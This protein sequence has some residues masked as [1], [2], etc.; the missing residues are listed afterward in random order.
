MLAAMAPRHLD[1]LPTR[2]TRIGATPGPA[3]QVEIQLGHVCNNRCVFCVSG[4]RTAE[5]L[6]RPLPTAPAL[7]ALEDAAATGARKVTFLGGEPTLQASLVP[8]IT[9]AID[10]GFHAIV[11]FTNGVK[12][13]RAGYVDDILALGAARGFAGFEWRFSIQGGDEAAHDDVTQKPGSFRRLVEGLHHLR[14]R[15]QD[16]TANACINERSY[17][18]L[19]G[20]VDLVRTH[21]IR[22]LHLDQV[23]PRD[24]GVRSDAELRAMMPRYS[25]MVPYFRAMLVRFDRELGPDYDVNVG[26]LPYCLMPERAA[27]IHHDGEAT[28]TVAADGDALSR[29][30]DKYA[31]KRRDKFH[32]PACAPC[33]FRPRCNGVFTKYAELHGV[34]EFVPVV[35]LSPRT[36]EPPAMKYRTLRGTT[37]QLSALGLRASTAP[38]ADELTAALDLGINWFDL[39]EGS[40]L[41]GLGERRHEAIVVT[42][43]AGPPAIMIAAVESA[44]QRHDLDTL[45]L[46]LL[47]WTGDDDLAA[48]ETLLAL[49]AKGKVTHLGLCLANPTLSPALRTTLPHLVCLRAPCSPYTRGLPAGLP[50][51]SLATGPQGQVQKPLA[52]LAC[53]PARSPAPRPGDRLTHALTTLAARLD[54]PP[55]TLALAW[56]L[57]QPDITVAQLDPA[58]HPSLPT[59]L[60]ALTLSGQS[61][62]WQALQPYLDAAPT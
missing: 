7:A 39:P 33:V 31:D 42:T 62:I 61:R 30:W 2:A 52:V 12:T 34:D 55:A 29:P 57:R 14:A 45:P 10:L 32:P 11:L 53:E 1:I 36:G 56:V 25:A 21:G 27:K 46:V 54:V 35:R 26:N 22:Q 13:A 28:Q 49:R 40:S 38:R 41:R 20:Y 44:R 18:S 48:F 16:I 17:R 24:A 47:R 15:D 60:R 50:L 58:S 5:G 8:A 23:R 51:L 43:L 6:A 37:L 59:A 9:R 3:A 19:P 4:Q